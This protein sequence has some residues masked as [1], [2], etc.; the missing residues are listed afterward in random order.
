MRLNYI[1]VSKKLRKSI[2]I[3]NII[4]KK[5]IYSNYLPI[6]MKIAEQ[7]KTKIKKTIQMIEKINITSRKEGNKELKKYMKRQ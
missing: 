1:F 7:T 2:L 3:A 6:I 4:K 5:S